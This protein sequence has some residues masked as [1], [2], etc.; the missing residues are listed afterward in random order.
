MVLV[1][2]VIFFALGLVVLLK[3]A[4]IFAENASKI[5]KSLG[6]SQIVIGL[7]LVAFTTSLPELAVSV[8]SV[9]REVPGIA[10]GNI[11]G[12]NI[13]NVGLVLGLAALLTKGIP[14]QRSE[15]KQGYIMLLVTFIAVLL[16][17][18]GLT[19]VKG[20]ILIIGLLFYIYYLSREK[21]FKQ[22]VVERIIEKT[23]LS[24]GLIFSVIGG[25]GVLI[26][27]ELMVSASTN[28]ATALSISETIIGLTIVAIGTSLPELATS[29]TAAIKRLE[30]IALGNII[31]SN[32]FNLMMVMGASAIAGSMV[33][34][35][36]LLLYSVPMMVLLS[37]LLVIFMKVENKLGRMD[38]AALLIIYAFFLYM[39]F[40]LV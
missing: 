30:G 34:E 19:P 5:A 25:A 26:G 40:F 18:D 10:M 38:G 16:I 9:F 8:L 23:N 27:A 4:S 36:T 24:K 31:G 14:V 22:S 37:V 28:I 17:I 6:V 15:L 11:I 33:I 3:G 2:D 12:S 1:T 35:P 39:R 20:A 29:V 13:A 32:I 7:T 21:D